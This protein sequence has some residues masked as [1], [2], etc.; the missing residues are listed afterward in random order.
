MSNRESSTSIGSGGV[1]LIVFVVLKLTGNISWPWIWVLSP[2][3]IPLLLVCAVV[4]VAS[5]VVLY[6]AWKGQR[7]G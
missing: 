2:I 7:N 5:I 1:L 4:L 6:R 3:W